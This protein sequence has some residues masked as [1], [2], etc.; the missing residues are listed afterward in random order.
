VRT[1]I[2]HNITPGNSPVQ[3]SIL[4][5]SHKTGKYKIIQSYARNN[6]LGRQTQLQDLLPRA[7]AWI[8]GRRARTTNG[9]A[10]GA[11]TS[12]VSTDGF[13]PG[14]R[15]KR[16]VVALSSPL[17]TAS[18]ITLPLAPAH[19]LTDQALATASATTMSLDLPQF[20]DSSRRTHFGG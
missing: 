6:R 12:D 17:S 1:R 10:R 16:S 14:G 4:P 7:C 9:R 20:P 2:L 3:R 18:A 11:A 15:N 8:T 13:A 19:Q 5:L